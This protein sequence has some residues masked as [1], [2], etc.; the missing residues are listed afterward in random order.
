M[1]VSA[2]VALTAG[3]VILWLGVHGYH[4]RLIRAF[5]ALRGVYDA[6]T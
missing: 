1:N 2:V 5:D 4:E 6:G 3:I